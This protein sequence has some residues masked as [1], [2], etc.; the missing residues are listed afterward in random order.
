V[1]GRPYESQREATRNALDQLQEDF[2][3]L[4]HAQRTLRGMVDSFQ[5]YLPDRASASG[6]VPRF[7]VLD[8]EAEQ[9]VT[10][11]LGV[12][13]R[14]P[15]DE[16][17][18]QRL[19]GDA[20]RAYADVGPRLGRQADALEQVVLDYD[21]ELTRI[22]QAVQRSRQ[23]KDDAGAQAQ[24]VADAAATLRETGVEV[25]ELNDILGRTR[26][27]AVAASGW[28]PADGLPALER[29]GTELEALA[30]AA[31]QLATD[32]PQR[33][34]KATTRRTSLR[35]AAEAV[36]ARLQRMRDDLATLRREYSIGNFAD[37]D[38]SEDSVR[39]NV[40]VALARL[41]D[42]D[43]L[44]AAGAEWGQPLR[45]LDEARAAVDAAKSRVDAPG[46]RLDA[47]RAIKADPE[48]L[49]KKVRFRL[50]DAQ[51]MVTQ[52]PKPDGA[53]VA[54]QLDALAV[55]LDGLRA[56]LRGPHPDY[57]GMFARGREHHRR[58]QGPGR[59]L[60]Q[61]VARPPTTDHRPPT[62][63]VGAG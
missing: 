7:R 41:R 11:Y 51:M 43:R 23:L 1:P 25:P 5:A 19:L 42:F 59:P 60:P 26:Q 30:G 17:L 9:L 50:R 46:D 14:H 54:R 56:S 13:D 24:R 47:L 31:E 22:G 3:R 53:T 58:G 37:I 16:D 32:L 29:A 18:D 48:E 2:R 34:A 62:A 35:T 33:I 44:V 4:D 45:L 52:S 40:G 8:R 27:A 61:P 39:E 15:F 28:Q 6:L 36:E 38:G 20:H 12:L 49:M 63:V 57:W 10:E 55:R 21:A